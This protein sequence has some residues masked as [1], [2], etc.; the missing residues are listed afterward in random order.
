VRIPLLVLAAFTALAVAASAHAQEACDDAWTQSALAAQFELGSDVPFR[1]A[2]WLGT[3][4]SFNSAA[5]TGAMEDATRFNQT[6]DLAGQLD[7]G[8]RSL[9]LDLHESPAGSGRPVICHSVPGTGCASVRDPAP[10]L[11]EIGDWL[12]EPEHADQVLL[13]YLEDGL[14]GEGVHDTAAAIVA[15]ELGDLVYRP[16]RAGCQEVPRRLT[17]DGV[18]AA[19][20]QVVIVSGC[21]AGAA[22]Q[23]TAFSWSGHREARPQAFADFPGCAP[24]FSRRQFDSRLIR[25][26][27]DA[28]RAGEPNADDG[29]TPETTAAMTRCGVDLLGFDRL[30]P[31][32][33][34]L[35]SAVWSWAGNEPAVGG[36]ALMRTGAK[37]PFGRWVSRPCEGLRAKPV[38]RDG[39]RWR[40]GRRAVSSDRARRWCRHHEGVFAVPRTGYENQLV[41]V[42]MRKRHTHAAQLG[43]R[44]RGG[45]WTA[46]DE[47]G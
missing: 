4:N 27:E 40:V 37:L 39:K 10:L 2:P 23:S 11:G 20:A 3:H 31:T 17:R 21:G 26:F 6:L 32:D 41:R 8:V 35:A 7:A 25:Y 9:E 33:P 36:C 14:D 1:N 5:E 30:E 45:E 24:D 28:T 18:L 12:R 22:W 47:R 38:C 13:L 44:L 16:T 46:L 19:G 29:L 43:Y 15:D 34:R 42:A